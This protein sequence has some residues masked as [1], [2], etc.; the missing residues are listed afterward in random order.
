MDFSSFIM[1]NFQKTLSDPEEIHILTGQ[2]AL[3]RDLCDL[4]DDKFV[5]LDLGCG[6]GGFTA[7]LA[8]RFPDRFI[9]AADIM[10]GRMRRVRKKVDKTG[11]DNVRFLRAEARF[12][13]GKCLPDNCIDRIHILCPDPWP[14]D[15]H[16]S[17]RLL[18][19][20]FMMFINRVLKE[21]GIFH[22][23]TDAGEYMES[24]MKTVASSGL[25][26]E[27]PPEVLADV[28]DIKTE[29]ERDWLAMG[30]TVPHVAWR[31]VKKPF[32]GM[33]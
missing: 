12:L 30:K 13:L 32:S 20:D 3:F 27:A 33:H 5:E 1:Q 31:A 2:Y 14:K 16:R 29:F 8:E 15:R 9:L 22:F 10:L 7:A 23:S 19:S 11:A 24:V 17:H 26:E 6:K 28:A 18:C 25:F 21:G 4:P